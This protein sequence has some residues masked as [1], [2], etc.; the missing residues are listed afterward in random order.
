MA[1]LFEQF[2]LQ[3]LHLHCNPL[4]SNYYLLNRE[5]ILRKL[6]RTIS[7]KAQM[8]Q[9]GRENRKEKIRKRKEEKEKEKTRYHQER[10]SMKK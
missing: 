8:P 3:L 5:E 1:A 2:R 10:F 7:H 9:S 4:Y 6:S